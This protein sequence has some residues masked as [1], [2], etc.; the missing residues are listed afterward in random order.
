MNF[1]KGRDGH[2]GSDAKMRDRFVRLAHWAALSGVPLLLLGA[3]LG[4]LSLA[5]ILSAAA[6]P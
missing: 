2:L 1:G 3:G 6:E 4:L 5:L